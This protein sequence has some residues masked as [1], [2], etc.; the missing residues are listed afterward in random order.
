[1]C[2][3]D[4]CLVIA[5]IDPEKDVDGFHPVNMGK[6]LIGQSGGFQPCT[7]LGIKVLLERA[8][9]E[10]AGK[11]VVILGRS[12]IVGKPLAAILMQKEKG[13]NA[14][15]T[16]AHSQ[17]K[18]LPEITQSADILIAAIGKSQFVTKGMVKPNA[19]VI[20]VGSNR[21][22]GKLV[23]DVDFEQ[24]KKTALKITPVPGGVG[25][26]TI[27]MLL[28]NTLRAFSHFLIF[29]LL[30]SSCQKSEQKD[31]YTYF[32]G[33]YQNERYQ[34]AVGK[35]FTKKEKETLENTIQEAFLSHENLY[36]LAKHFRS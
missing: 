32:S 33:T 7:P 24:V 26:M 23:G 22:N 21:V 5:V 31:P 2:I 11:H 10:V 28:K 16:I 1:M 29:L 13:C 9:V 35:V 3:R 4:R 30:L 25:P 17:T 14:T 18:N 19:V 15:V 8:N 27:A 20:D 12:N 34:I 36:D 6:L